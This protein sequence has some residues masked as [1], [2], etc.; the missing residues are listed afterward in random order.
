MPVLVLLAALAPGGPVHA[1][2]VPE[3]R[4]PAVREDAAPATPAG[5]AESATPAE[6]ADPDDLE[7]P[8]GI[9]GV[10]LANI[11]SDRA[12]PACETALKAEPETART[13]YQLARA[14]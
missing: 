2:E 9:A 1:Q 4:S 8:A 10:A 5:N 14:L 7:R 3:S 13:A 12:V 11:E 6:S